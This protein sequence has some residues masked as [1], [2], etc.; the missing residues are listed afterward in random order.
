MQLWGHTATSSIVRLN[1]QKQAPN[2]HLLAI[3]KYILTQLTCMLLAFCAKQAASVCS[4]VINISTTLYFNTINEFIKVVIGCLIRNLKKR[5]TFTN[6]NGG[7]FYVG[8]S[9]DREE[10]CSQYEAS[11]LGFCFSGSGVTCRH[12]LSRYDTQSTF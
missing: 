2:P 11:P 6:A 12:C 5:P 3:H 10:V 9:R 4:L 7:K 8:Q 1:G